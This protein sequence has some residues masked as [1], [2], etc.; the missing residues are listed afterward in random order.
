VESA[1]N[2]AEEYELRSKLQETK[3]ASL[4]TDDPQ[5]L[6]LVKSD[7]APAPGKNQTT[8]NHNKENQDQ[9]PVTAAEHFRVLWLP[10]DYLQ[11]HERI[12]AHFFDWGKGKHAKIQQRL[13][14]GNT[15]TDNLQ[16]QTIEQELRTM[17]QL[18]TPRNEKKK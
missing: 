12:Q 7:D 17:K 1:T 13:L 8:D 15:D 2:R 5:T 11:H 16:I 18:N 10:R 6:L 3:L 4:A 9:V 14:K